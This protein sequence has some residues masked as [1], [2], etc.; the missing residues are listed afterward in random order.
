MGIVVGVDGSGESCAALEYAISEAGLRS[1][2]VTVVAAYVPPQLAGAFYGVAVAISEVE[3]A[4]KVEVETREL[5]DR[6]LLEHQPAPVVHLL[7]V[8]TRSPAQAVLDASG[9]ADLVVVGHRG[10]GEFSSV[11]LGS[12][13]LQCVLHASCPV[14]VVRPVRSCTA[15]TIQVP[16][17]VGASPTTACDR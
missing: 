15:P 2:D 1:T 6:V 4:R 12:V 14:T 11:M 3:F 13:G 7:V 5:I 8:P 9:N 10:R 17:A 16:V